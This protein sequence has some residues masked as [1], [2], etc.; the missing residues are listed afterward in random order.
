MNWYIVEPGGIIRLANS[1]DEGAKWFDE[2]SEVS[3]MGGGRRVAEDIIK[4]VRISTVFLGLDHGF[5]SDEPILFE[6][7]IFGGRYADYQERYKTF[8][9]AMEGH[10]KAVALVRNNVG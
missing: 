7:M 8:L 3:F 10:D 4:G 6:T 5:G 2:N 9:K 1:L